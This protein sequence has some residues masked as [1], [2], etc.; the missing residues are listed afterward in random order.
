ML[1][2][3]TVWGGVYGGGGRGGVLDVFSMQPT[4]ALW[5]ILS[6]QPPENSSFAYFNHWS[7]K[8][9]ANKIIFIIHPDSFYAQKPNKS[10]IIWRKRYLHS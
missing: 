1:Q 8:T 7:G 2:G 6:P 3:W 9:A 4:F 10:D 5:K